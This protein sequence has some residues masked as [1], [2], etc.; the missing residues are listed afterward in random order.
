M[1]TIF[2]IYLIS[3]ISLLL[4]SCAQ[5][6]EPVQEDFSF[7]ISV[8]DTEGNPVEGLEVFVD[9]QAPYSQ[10]YNSRPITTIGYCLEEQ[11]DVT[12]QISDLNNTVLNTFYEGIKP[13]ERYYMNYSANETDSGE[14]INGNYIFLKYN[15]TARNSQ[16]RAILFEETK[17]MCRRTHP[18]QGNFNVGS[19]NSQGDFQTD[20]KPYFPHLYDLPDIEHYDEEGSSMGNSPVAD[21]A[22]IR[23][24]DPET[25]GGQTFEVAVFEGDNHFNLVLATRSNTISKPSVNEYPV[26]LSSFTAVIDN[27]DPVLNWTTQ[28]E[29]NNMGWNIYRSE[30]E[31]TEDYIQINENMIEGAGT[32]E[33]QTDYSYSDNT[34]VV[35]GSTYWYWL[36]A[37]DMG[38]ATN[39]FGPI[40]IEIP[41]EEE[42]PPV[43]PYE[44]GIMNY[45]NPFN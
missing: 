25:G 11:S 22:N 13:A 33:E 40:S 14:P 6:N 34:E 44:W 2:R 4:F 28:S 31:S 43:I 41:E 24:I 30:T 42:E 16:T 9:Y 8:K 19:T 27:G 26:E 23:I 17:F 20:Y 18:H 1:K 12:I 15:L 10:N 39:L 7:S 37:V 38:G 35:P 5:S 3:I 21:E 36:Q 32:T 45:P 29:M